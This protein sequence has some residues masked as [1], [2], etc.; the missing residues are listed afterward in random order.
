MPKIKSDGR[1]ENPIKTA[2]MLLLLLAI[3]IVALPFLVL[4]YLWGIYLRVRFWRIARHEGKFVLLVYSDSPNW[5][6]YVEQ[7]ILPRVQDHAIILN[8]SERARWDNGS[9]AVQAFQHWGGHADFNPLGVVFCGIARVRVF[10]FY[11][12]FL[13]HKRGNAVPLQQVENS[14]F[15]AVMTA[16]GARQGGRGQD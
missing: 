3:C 6:S 11:R 5:K 12:A 10:R 8:W 16:R 7:S 13:E 2:L 15:E 4:Q 9:W 14:F 1:R